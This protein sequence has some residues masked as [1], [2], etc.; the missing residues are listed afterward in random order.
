MEEND[1]EACSVCTHTCRHRCSDCCMTV[2]L[3]CWWCCM[4]QCWA[5]SATVHP[6]LCVS[7]QP[8]CVC[9]CVAMVVC[10]GVACVSSSLLEDPRISSGATLVVGSCLPVDILQQRRIS[11]TDA[12]TFVQRI[13]LVNN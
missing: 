2:V 13:I 1:E 11:D 4:G 12:V 9:V 7:G 6:A 8:P 10:G 3:W 5:E